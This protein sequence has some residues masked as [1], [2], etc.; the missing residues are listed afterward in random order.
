M[1]RWEAHIWGR[2]I[3]KGPGKQIYLGGF[4]T[5][6]EAAE[7]HDLA[8]LQLQGPSAKTNFHIGR[9]TASHLLFCSLRLQIHIDRANGRMPL[10]N[11]ILARHFVFKDLSIYGIGIYISRSL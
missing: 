2:A 6:E 8:A 3:N 4:V 5:P 1:L 7:A 10:Y 9:Y 11:H